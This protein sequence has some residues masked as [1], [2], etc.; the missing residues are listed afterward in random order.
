MSGGT[1]G[2]RAA[3]VFPACCRRRRRANLIPA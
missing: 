3:I 2:F 1:L